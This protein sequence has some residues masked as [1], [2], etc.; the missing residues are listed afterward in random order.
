MSQPTIL[1][2]LTPSELITTILARHSHPTTVFICW[3]RADF[4]NALSADIETQ[5]QEQQLSE[6]PLLLPPS[7]HQLVVSQQ[8]CLIFVSSVVH[9]R[10]ALATFAGFRSRLPT[11]PPQ[12]AAPDAPDSLPPLCLVYGFINLHRGG[13]EWSARGLG[14][15][16]SLVV[17]AASRNS[18]VAVLA[19]APLET[20][21]LSLRVPII[22]GCSR[23]S[24][25]SWN[26]PTVPL[27]IILRR[28]FREDA[29]EATSSNEASV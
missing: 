26:S 1:A 22:S 2:P 18:L 25:G 10:A 6:H 8:I 4:L 14:I 29:V 11:S 17:V 16:A 20:S 19:D 7:I 13:Y 5:K 27:R 15:S 28:W 9:L 12:E 24:D 21:P 3:P 23:R